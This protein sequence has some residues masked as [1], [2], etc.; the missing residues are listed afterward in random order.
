MLK[1]IFKIIYYLFLGGLAYYVYKAFHRKNQASPVNN[2]Y[3]PGKDLIQGGEFVKDPHCQIYFPKNSAHV[4][5]H[6]G[7]LYYFCSDECK[8]NFL[9]AQH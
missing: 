6:D 4:L 2:P 5:N 3:S 8:Q 1:I 9:L 7:K